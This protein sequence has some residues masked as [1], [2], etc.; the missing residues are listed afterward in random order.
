M[1]EF[2]QALS[3]VPNEPAERTLHSDAYE[4]K[5]PTETF[6]NGFSTEE[7]RLFGEMSMARTQ[8]DLNDAI[9][10]FNEISAGKSAEALGMS[11]EDMLIEGESLTLA[12]GFPVLVSR[13]HRGVV[14]FLNPVQ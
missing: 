14:S 12:N 8:E 9:A 13:T 6:T 7:S 10:L 1:N 11:L 3:R 2:P 5:N 4:K